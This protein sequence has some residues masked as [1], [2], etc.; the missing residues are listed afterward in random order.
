MCDELGTDLFVHSIFLFISLLVVSSNLLRDYDSLDILKALLGVLT[1]LKH[2]AL[3]NEDLLCLL[4]VW[5][6]R[7]FVHWWLLNINDLLWLVIFNADNLWLLLM[8]LILFFNLL[9]DFLVVSSSLLFL[10]RGSLSI[11]SRVS[12]PFALPLNWL[13]Q[14]SVVIHQLPCQS[15]LVGLEDL[16]QNCVLGMAQFF[17]DGF[18]RIVHVLVSK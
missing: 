3:L 16:F 8:D 17:L 15:F 6:V 7:H 11:L 13:L 2:L 14:L 9:L 18:E 4:Q 10:H 5:G 12:S 1:R